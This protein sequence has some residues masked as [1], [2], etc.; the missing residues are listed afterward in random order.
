V[1]GGRKKGRPWPENGPKTH[2]KKRRGRK[3]NNK[4]KRSRRR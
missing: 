2:R 1:T 4:K 3:R